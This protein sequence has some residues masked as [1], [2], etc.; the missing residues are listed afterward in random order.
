[1]LPMWSKRGATDWAAVARVKTWTRQCFA[2][3]A[4]CTIF[5]AEVAC[6]RPGCPPVESVTAFWTAPNRRNGFKAFKPIEAV[7]EDD[8][9]PS[10]TKDAIIADRPADCC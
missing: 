1:M 5:V 10:W 2:L 7:V 4:D 6:G 9:P 8:L 3:G